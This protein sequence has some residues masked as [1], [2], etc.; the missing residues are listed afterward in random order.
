MLLF[1]H[2]RQTQYSAGSDQGHCI[3]SGN[4]DIIHSIDDWTGAFPLIIPGL[5]IQNIIDTKDP[6]SRANKTQTVNN[7]VDK[8]K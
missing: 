8:L 1:S 5:V 7:S 6:L 2:Y 3:V 4:C